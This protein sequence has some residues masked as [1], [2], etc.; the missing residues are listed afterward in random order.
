MLKN[1]IFGVLGFHVGCAFIAYD[2]KFPYCFFS[3]GFALSLFVAKTIDD[4]FS[5]TS[6]Y[7]FKY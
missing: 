5:Q 2:I 6:N 3:I 4:V 7:K 1:I